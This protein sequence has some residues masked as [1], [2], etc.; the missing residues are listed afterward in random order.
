MDCRSVQS[1]PATRR[2]RPVRRVEARRISVME[3][4]E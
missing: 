4:P 3:R 1:Y 2:T